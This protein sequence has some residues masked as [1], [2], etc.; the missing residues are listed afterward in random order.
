MMSEKGGEKI[1]AGV[2]AAAA[3]RRI[4][5]RRKKEGSGGL[6]FGTL[7]QSTSPLYGMMWLIGGIWVMVFLIFFFSSFM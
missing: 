2:V 4:K 6:L 3:A 1:M 7:C 5:R